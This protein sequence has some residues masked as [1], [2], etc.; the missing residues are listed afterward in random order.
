MKRSEYRWTLKGITSNIDSSTG[1]LFLH[2]T[3]KIIM[4][5]MKIIYCLEFSRSRVRSDLYKFWLMHLDKVL[6]LGRGMKPTTRTR[7]H[8]Q[9][10]LP[11]FF[12]VTKWLYTKTLFKTL[13][14]IYMMHC[15][16]NVW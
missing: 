14:G 6:K 8:A 5:N 2:F 16:N 12:E 11:E 1:K 10:P 13:W 15:I 3:N 7:T 4:L 9:N